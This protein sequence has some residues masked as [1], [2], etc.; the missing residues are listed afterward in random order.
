MASSAF[1]IR[2]PRLAVGCRV[3]VASPDETMLLV[4][5]GAL[6]LTGAGREIVSLIDGLVTVEGIA[7]ILRE[8]H[9]SEASGTIST[10][11]RQFIEKLHARGVVVFID[12]ARV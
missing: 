12:E 7:D 4:P 3:K 6:R 2:V 10:D 1:D 9:A 11:V 8:K 5:E